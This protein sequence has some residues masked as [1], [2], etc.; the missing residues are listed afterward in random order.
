ML[1]GQGNVHRGNI[2][3]EGLLWESVG[4]GNA[5]R[6]C[7]QESSHESVSFRHQLL[8]LYDVAIASVSFRYQLRRFCIICMYVIFVYSRS[9]QI[10]NF[11]NK[12]IALNIYIYFYLH[13]VLIKT[14]LRL[15][16]LETAGVYLKISIV[17]KVIIKIFQYFKSVFS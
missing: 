4:L 15:L 11:K 12:Q 10:Y 7:V 8:C 6:R 2:R 13:K 5:C 1:P 16:N 3:R 9:L 14:D 17:K